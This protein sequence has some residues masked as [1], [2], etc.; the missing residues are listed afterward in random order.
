MPDDEVPQFEAVAFGP[1][2]LGGGADLESMRLEIQLTDSDGRKLVLS[3][4][5]ELSWNLSEALAP[6]H[7]ERKLLLKLYREARTTVK[8]HNADEKGQ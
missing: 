4:H 5:P 7:P 6:D 8:G 1:L 2:M 3:M